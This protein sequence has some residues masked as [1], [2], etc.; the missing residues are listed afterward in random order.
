MTCSKCPALRRK[1]YEIDSDWCA[2]AEE[3]ESG[4]VFM[5]PSFG[6]PSGNHIS[7][8]PF[9]KLL[10]AC[11]KQRDRARVAETQIKKLRAEIAQFI[12]GEENPDVCQYCWGTG[13]IGSVESVF[14]ERL[15]RK[16]LAFV[17]KTCSYCEGTQGS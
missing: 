15:G 7:D 13:M 17:E 5:P 14:V 12:Y 11:H 4:A 9:Y 1:V 6:K 10:K 3:F 2:V 8:C 16:S